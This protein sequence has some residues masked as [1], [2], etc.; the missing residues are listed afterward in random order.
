MHE[1]R[2]AA[3]FAVKGILNWVFEQRKTWATSLMVI[4]SAEFSIF[5]SRMPNFRPYNAQEGGL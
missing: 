5:S 3:H 4:M 2:D 1:R